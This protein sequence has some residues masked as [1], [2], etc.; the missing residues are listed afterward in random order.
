MKDVAIF[1]PTRNVGNAL[2]ATLD[3][4]PNDVKTQVGEIFVID[5]DSKDRTYEIGV[6]YKTKNQIPNLNVYKNKK[7]LGIGGSEKKAFDYV[8]NKNFKYMVLLH[9]DAQYAPESVKDILKPLQKGEADFVFGSRMLGNP[10]EGGMPFWRFFGNRVLTIIANFI[11]SL[12]LTEFHSGFRAF[13]VE[14]LKKI[15]FKDLSNDY[16]F[17]H[18]IIILF[19]LTKKK[20]VEIPIPTRYAE[21]STSPSVSQTIKYSGNVISDLI[22][23]IFHKCRIVK[24]KKFLLD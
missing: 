16:H 8:I 1:I 21:E 12:S 24:Q 10:L 20:I 2:T 17:D 13:N 9:G 19:A 11:L 3:R 7:N 14:V 18:E 4:I 23:I 22:K 6:E 15:P 5:N